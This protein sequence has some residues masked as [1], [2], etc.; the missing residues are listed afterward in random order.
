MGLPHPLNRSSNRQYHAPPSLVDD[1]GPCEIKRQCRRN[2]SQ[3]APEYGQA[4][5]AGQCAR[6]QQIEGGNQRRENQHQ[7]ATFFPGGN[8]QISGENTPE[9]Q[10]P[11]DERA[12]NALGEKV[13]EQG[14]APPERAVSAERHKAKAVA[15]EA[16][17][18]TR[19]KLRRS[20]E[21]K[22]GGQHHRHIRAGE[23]AG[24]HHAQ[25]PRGQ[26]KSG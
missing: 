11:A 18:H 23:P 2:Q 10:I 6:S 8:P 17:R 24:I 9:Q 1:F 12:A 26:G 13:D 21:C 19:N 4:T 16:L 15:N 22:G 7:G 5:V 3:I 25:Q 14:E 20:T